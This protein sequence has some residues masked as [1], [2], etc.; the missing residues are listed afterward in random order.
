[1]AGE[2]ADYHE[3]VRMAYTDMLAAEVG[4]HAMC[5]EGN[6]TDRTEHT[7]SSELSLKSKLKFLPPGPGRFMD[8]TQSGTDLMAPRPDAPVFHQF[9]IPN[10]AS[11]QHFQATQAKCDYQ[12]RTSYLY[13][14]LIR[15]LTYCLLLAGTLRPAL[16]SYLLLTTSTSYLPRPTCYLQV[17]PDEVLAKQ[18]QQWLQQC[19]QEKVSPL[20]RHSINDRF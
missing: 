15:R 18:C 13:I 12:V 16:T 10:V 8:R 4:E 2:G 5:A 11:D 9:P 19:R 20:C 1:M 14:L 7:T 6:C 3:T 17:L